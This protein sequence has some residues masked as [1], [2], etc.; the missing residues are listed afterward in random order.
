MKAQGSQRFVE[1]RRNFGDWHN[2]RVLVIEGSIV[3]IEM[4]DETSTRLPKERRCRGGNWHSRIGT[5][6]IVRKRILAN[7]GMD[8]LCFPG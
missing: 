4:L 2:H 8:V 1:I 7:E 5:K 3:G 6:L